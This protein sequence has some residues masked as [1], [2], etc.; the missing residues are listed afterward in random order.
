MT[1]AYTRGEKSDIGAKRLSEA[2]SYIVGDDSTSPSFPRIE[3]YDAAE[4]NIDAPEWLDW[5]RT[6]AKLLLGGARIARTGRGYTV[7]PQDE[8]INKAILGA[9]NKVIP[10]RINPETGLP[11]EEFRD[12]C[13]HLVIDGLRTFADGKVSTYYLSQE[14]IEYVKK[15]G[16]PTAATSYQLR[17]NNR[18]TTS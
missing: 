6:R 4:P 16:T 3:K 18:R 5:H 8:T 13:Q 2:H 15:L 7:Y 17:P 12:L 14:A 10:S 9:A 11:C 1:D